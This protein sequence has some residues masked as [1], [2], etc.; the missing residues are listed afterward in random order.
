M[1][2]FGLRGTV[3]PVSYQSITDLELG[4]ENTLA[5]VFDVLVA[6]RHSSCHSGY[7][8]HVAAPVTDL[9]RTSESRNTI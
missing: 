3:N 9:C 2:L 8:S 6:H 4:S 7:T 5:I 1:E